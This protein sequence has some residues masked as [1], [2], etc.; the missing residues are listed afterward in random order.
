MLDA[1][2]LRWRRGQA[3]AAIAA[4]LMVLF[5]ALALSFAGRTPQPI[6]PANSLFA[7]VSVSRACWRFR[8]VLSSADF[9]LR[10][11]FAI[12]RVP[13]HRTA[14]REESEEASAEAAL[15]DEVVAA[16]TG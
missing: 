3:T 11:L 7:P 12:K 6:A 5:L 9:S 1:S 16:S 13:P 14:S 10:P 8:P 2:F 15:S 4:G